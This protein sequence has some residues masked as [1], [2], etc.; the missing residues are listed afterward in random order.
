MPRLTFITGLIV[1]IAKA[2]KVA[3]YLLKPHDLLHFISF[4]F[5]DN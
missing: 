2:I 4:S 5:N 1:W 3:E